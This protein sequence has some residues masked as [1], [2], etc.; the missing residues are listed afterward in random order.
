MTGMPEA[1]LARELELCYACCA[2]VV[3][4]AAGLS[5][6]TISMQEIEKQLKSG[7]EHVRQLL[8]DVISHL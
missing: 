4:P 6:D 1:A 2:L 8:V 7:I 5:T 3:N